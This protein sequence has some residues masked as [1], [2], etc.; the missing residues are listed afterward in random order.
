MLITGILKVNWM[1]I[2]KECSNI[3]KISSMVR[4]ND[5]NEWSISKMFINGDHL[6][7]GLDKQHF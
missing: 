2:G 6:D 5:L 1:K 7:T 3:H 4:V